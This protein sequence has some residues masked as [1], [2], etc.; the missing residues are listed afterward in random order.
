[1]LTLPAVALCGSAASRR[2]PPERSGGAFSTLVGAPSPPGRP[3]L[4]DRVI[5]PAAAPTEVRQVAT[6]ELLAEL[7]LQVA[8]A[9]GA[10]AAKVCEEREHTK[11]LA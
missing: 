10:A 5:P 4:R 8:V 1:M 11:V 7:A 3:R 2:P 9:C 6:E